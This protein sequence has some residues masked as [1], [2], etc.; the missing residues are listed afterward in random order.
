MEENNVYLCKWKKVGKDFKLW[1]PAEPKV[2][3]EGSD[4]EDAAETLA[5]KVAD[6]YSDQEA[7]LEFNPPAPSEKAEH[8]KLEILVLGYNESS[9]AQN[10]SADLF[11]NGLC[12][13]CRK[14]FAGRTETQ[15][16]ISRLPK[17]NVAGTRNWSPG[18]F[19]FSE[20]FAGLLTAEEKLNLGLREVS[21]RTGSERKFFEVTGTPIARFVGVKG[22]TYSPLSCWKCPVCGASRIYPRM[23]PGKLFQ[24]HEFVCRKDLPNPMPT[25][26]VLGGHGM[27]LTPC[28]LRNRWQQI[29]SKSETKGIATSRI[30]VIGEDIA[31]YDPPLPVYK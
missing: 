13:T 15:L 17:N 18:I 24:F 2:T 9:D 31:D 6:F 14:P 27:S 29:I 1:L 12:P 30:G 3:A 20:P 16:I 25:I 28:V 5:E 21:S 10:I 7:V 26:F 22:A 23:P 8:R 4:F 19:L 11:I